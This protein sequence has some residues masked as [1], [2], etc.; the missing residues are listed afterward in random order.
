MSTIL[1]TKKVYVVGSQLNYANFITKR[2]LVDNINDADIVIF[3]GGEDV[4]PSLYNCKPHYTTY[5]NLQRDLAEMEEFRKI[6]PNQ[7]VIGICR[8]L[9]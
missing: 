4:H 6:K 1:K 5:A 3:T 9:R 7:L 8:G 2:E